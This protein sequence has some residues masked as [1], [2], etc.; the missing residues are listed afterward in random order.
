MVSLYGT[1]DRFWGGGAY[2]SLIF[3]LDW[4]VLNGTLNGL[5]FQHFSDME[6]ALL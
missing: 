3:C 6:M 4:R 1:D 5:H 2:A